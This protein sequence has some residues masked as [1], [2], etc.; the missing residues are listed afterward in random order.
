MIIITGATGQLG[1]AIAMQLIARLPADQVGVSVR[2]PRKA[3]DLEAL[4]VRVR[5]GDF[6][7]PASLSHAFEDAS[8]IL[9]VSSNARSQGGDPL[10]QHAAV[11]NAARTVGARRIVYTSQIAASPTS[12]FGPALDHAATE[13]MLAESGLAW[14]ALRNGFYASSALGMMKKAFETGV[15]ATPAG[16]KFVW[17]THDD[18]AEAAAIIL[19]N[20]GKY[21]GPTPPLTGS[22][23]LG[24]ADLT[25][26]ASEIL[27]RPIRHETFPDDQLAARLGVPAGAAKFMLGMYT[28]S[29]AGEFGP[30]NPTLAELLGRPPETM[31][32]LMTATLKV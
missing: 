1:H 2:D 19:A 11:I 13:K 17:T 7:D 23:A 27:G 4:G 10:A 24:F 29:R 22:Q 20:E 32:E 21:G 18:L 16:G 12:A 28:A 15:M 8:Q 26:M 14:T 31:R 5:Q 9:L 6:S 25:E 30:V 3:A